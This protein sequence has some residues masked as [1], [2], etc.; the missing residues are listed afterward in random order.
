[1]LDSSLDELEQAERSKAA[2]RVAVTKIPRFFFITYRPVLIRPYSK[3]TP[4]DAPSNASN[5]PENLGV[6]TSSPLAGHLV[7]VGGGNAFNSGKVYTS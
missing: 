1:M 3:C 2:D 4:L 7:W 5:R 6:G